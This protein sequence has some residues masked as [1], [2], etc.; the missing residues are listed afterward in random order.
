MV[1]QI[2]RRLFKSMHGMARNQEYVTCRG[3][4]FHYLDLV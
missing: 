1:G 3:A 2:E 4:R